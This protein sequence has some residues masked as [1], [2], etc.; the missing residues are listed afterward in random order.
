MALHTVLRLRGS[1][2]ATEEGKAGQGS[3]GGALGA[4]NREQKGFGGTL[5]A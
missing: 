5:R 4:G 2:V 1:S 3:G